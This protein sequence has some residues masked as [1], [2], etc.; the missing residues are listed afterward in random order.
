MNAH[1]RCQKAKITLIS[2]GVD[3][4]EN[5]VI[6]IEPL[7]NTCQ[8][9]D[10]HSSYGVN[11]GSNKP[12]ET[13]QLCS[14]IQEEDSSLIIKSCGQTGDIAFPKPEP[15]V[16]STIQHYTTYAVVRKLDID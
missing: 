7:G 6:S 3:T 2:P 12:S 9:T 10:T 1:K 11:L 8:I 5:D 13:K 15:T 14:S 16:K 4:G